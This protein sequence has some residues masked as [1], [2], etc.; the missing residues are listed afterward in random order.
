MCDARVAY[1]KRLVHNFVS[2]NDS[3][4]F[5]YV[6]SFSSQP[7][8]PSIMSLDSCVADTPSS[9]ANLCNQYFH[10]VYDNSSSSPAIP[11]QSLPDRSLCSIDIS[12]HDTFEALCFIKSDKA[13]GGDGIPPIILKKAA[14]AL[15]EPIHHLFHLCVTQSSIPLQWRDH[16]ITPIPKSGDKTVI[17]NYRPISLLSS[18]SKVFEKIIFDKIFDFLLSASVSS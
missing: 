11:P 13:M 12:L 3:G 6:R 18:I 5:R 15:L 10:S 2:H 7:R 4:I 14:T 8:L 16:Y 9:I 1:E 17:S